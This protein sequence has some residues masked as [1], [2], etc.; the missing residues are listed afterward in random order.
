[1]VTTGVSLSILAD[2]NGI[3]LTGRA[4]DGDIDSLVIV[5]E[6]LTFDEVGDGVGVTMTG[7]LGVE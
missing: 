1:M 6:A 2:E 7:L 5:G 3:I 4:D